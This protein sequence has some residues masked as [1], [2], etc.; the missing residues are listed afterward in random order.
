[1]SR[2]IPT[3]SFLRIL[4]QPLFS[5]YPSSSQFT[6]FFLEIFAADLLLDSHV[7][8]QYWRSCYNTRRYSTQAASHFI[9][10]PIL[11]FIHAAFAGTNVPIPSDRTP[12]GYHVHVS[13]SSGRWNTTV[14]AA[15]TA[16]DYSVSWNEFFNIYGTPLTF[17][18]WLIPKVFRT[19]EPIHLEIRALYESGLEP[20]SAFETTFEQ[21]LGCDGQSSKSSFLALSYVVVPDI[22]SKVTLPA[23]NDQSTS[24]SLNINTTPRASSSSPEVRLFNEPR[25][26]AYS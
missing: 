15:G 14:K 11:T 2:L 9:L 6:H 12:I 19:S 13:T 18:Q 1:M 24:L 16:E 8:L 10:L 26:R 20:V 7:Q 25:H 22:G 4:H 3:H 17:F 21:L 5:P 23:I